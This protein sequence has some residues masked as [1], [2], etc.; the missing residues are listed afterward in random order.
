[1]C[2]DVRVFLNGKFYNLDVSYLF[3]KR[4]SHTHKI[5]LL[6][7]YFESSNN[8]FSKKIYTVFVAFFSG[9]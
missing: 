6:K 1:M 8:K 4:F 7:Q 2:E 9:Q 3:H 5:T